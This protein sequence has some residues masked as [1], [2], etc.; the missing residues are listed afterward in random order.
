MQIYSVSGKRLGERSKSHM[1]E[2]SSNPDERLKSEIS[3]LEHK[4]RKKYNEDKKNEYRIK[5]NQERDKKNL[6]TFMDQDEFEELI[7]NCD[8]KDEQKLF[9]YLTT[10]NNI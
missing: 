8:F 10:Y 5:V 2:F 7:D 4:K 6:Y 3:Y 1:A 9:E